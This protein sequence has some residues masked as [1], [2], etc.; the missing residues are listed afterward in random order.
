VANALIRRD[1]E[2]HI[3]ST[4]IFNTILKDRM[5]EDTNSNQQ[6]LKIKETLQQVNLQ[7]KF[8]YYELQEDGILTYREKIYVP[9]SSD[10][11]T[12]VVR[13]MHN[14]TYARHPRYQKTFAA[15]KIQYF[16]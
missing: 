11:K 8:N 15:V 5:L 16:G 12:I 10:L 6:H 14:V 13:E 9:N 1:H 7:H 3:S 2:M 4:N